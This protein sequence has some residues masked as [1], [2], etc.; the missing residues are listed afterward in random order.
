MSFTAFA[1]D[2]RARLS[3]AG[4]TT[5]GTGIGACGTAPPGGGYIQIDDWRQADA[6]VRR[7]AMQLAAWDLGETF[8][9]WVQ[10]IA[11]GCPM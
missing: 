7:V 11:I 10:G 2:L 1:A 4:I 3:A 9:V 8:G 5:L 6:V